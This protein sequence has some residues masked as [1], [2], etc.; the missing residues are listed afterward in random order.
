[1][2]YAL[3]ISHH[4]LYNSSIFWRHQFPVTINDKIT[5]SGVTGFMPIVNGI[6]MTLKRGEV[7]GLIGESGAGKSTLG[8]AAMG[9][10]RR[11]CRIAS[12]S[13]VF[14]GIELFEA[15]EDVKPI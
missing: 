8:L 4:S 14:D 6:D 10:T 5:S 12:G 13:I 11:G 15:S 9:Y 2:N 3:G 1:M 7:L